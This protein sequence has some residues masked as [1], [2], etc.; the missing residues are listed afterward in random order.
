MTDNCHV[1][2]VEDS[3]PLAQI[4]RAY[5]NNTEYTTSHAANIEDARQALEASPPNIIL[6]DV[7]LPDGSGIDL[8]KNIA[9]NHPD[10]QVVV[11]TAHGSSQMALDAIEVGA[12]DFLTKPFDAARLM[13]T[14]KNAR[15]NVVLSRRVQTLSQLERD[16]YAGL[17]GKSAIMQSVYRKLD[18]V[19]ATDAPAFIVGE[20]GS[21]QE[22]AARAIHQNSS[23]NKR[24]FVAIH[25]GSKPGELLEKELFGCSAYNGTPERT[26]AA[27]M[28]DGG[29]L[30]LN[31]LTEMDMELQKKLFYFIQSGE[32]T[33]VGANQ[34]E[35]SAV[36]FICSTNLDPLEAVQTGRLRQDL[37]YLLH[38]I[39]IELPPLRERKEDISMLAKHLLL[40]INKKEG[41][42]FKTI[43]PEVEAIFNG[44]RWPGN[45]AELENVLKNIVVLST[46]TSI[47]K[48]MLP[49]KM[50]SLSENKL[51]SSEPDWL[52]LDVHQLARVDTA[53]TA[54]QI[55][56]LWLVEKDTI[57]QAIAACGGNV[58]K[59][60]GLLEVAP[61]TIYRKVQAWNR[62]NNKREAT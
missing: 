47:K 57:E 34:S 31:E 58:N 21:G 24:Q 5:L 38:V 13:V 45:V 30:F 25:C 22:I 60:A 14:L 12:T 61:S 1:L 40:D 49:K 52:N 11:M 59:A 41:K 19:A 37:Y 20:Q 33:K 50:L 39:P 55:R 48:E 54:D 2:V 32:F 27:A 43:E 53:M 18:S 26:G 28:C 15:E 36:R 10:I 16:Q 62:E 7:E 4:Y 51:K 3:L 6:L 8:L 35:Q 56:P 17:V 23:R 46:G 9:V 29:T 44:Y 42:A